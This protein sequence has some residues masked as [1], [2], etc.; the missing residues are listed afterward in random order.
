MANA[1][2]KWLKAYKELA[3]MGV[4]TTEKLSEPEYEEYREIIIGALS[5]REREDLMFQV[6]RESEMQEFMAALTEIDEPRS[7]DEIL[8]DKLY[9]KLHKR[10]MFF[11]YCHADESI[12]DDVYRDLDKILPATIIRDEE[13]LIALDSIRKFAGRIKKED[14]VCVIVTNSFLRSHYCMLE[15]IKLLERDDYK[16]RTYPYI[17]NVN[18]YKSLR[19]VV[20]YWKNKYEAAAEESKS[21]LSGT[22][23]EVEMENRELLLIATRIGEF[24]HWIT[25]SLSIRIDRFAEEVKKMILEDLAE[26]GLTD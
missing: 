1:Y 16:Q 11:S 12:A 26:E 24:I 8:N 25:D 15:V 21:L 14:Y 9:E 2:D 4:A 17:A 5:P 19:A 20:A 22:N 7:R 23:V 13:H 6:E 10:S 3:A 18:I